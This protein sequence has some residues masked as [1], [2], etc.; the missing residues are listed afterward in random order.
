MQQSMQAGNQV[1]ENLVVRLQNQ[2]KVTAAK[3]ISSRP[4]AEA[5]IRQW[6]ELLTIPAG[7]KAAE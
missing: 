5:L 6:E 2:K 1:Y 4:P 7:S 3:W